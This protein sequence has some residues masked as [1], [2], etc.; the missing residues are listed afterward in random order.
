MVA[1]VFNPSRSRQRQV[2]SMQAMW[3]PFVLQTISMTISLPLSFCIVFMGMKRKP[4]HVT[5][6]GLCFLSDGISGVYLLDL[7]TLTIKYEGRL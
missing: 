2:T 4:H 7:L 5:Q 1:H 3:Y 6:A